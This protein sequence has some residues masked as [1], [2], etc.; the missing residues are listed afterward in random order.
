MKQGKNFIHFVSGS[1]RIVTKGNLYYW[2]WVLFLLVLIVVG[3][4]A[5]FHQLNEGLIETN[6]RD[7]VSWGFYI[8]NFTFLVGV[9]AAAVVLVIPAY[10]YHWGPIKEIV[11]LGELLAVSACVMCV[12]F[13]TVDIG[14]PER[15]WHMIP[16]LGVLNV[17]ASILDWDVVALNAYLLLNLTIVT[18]LLYCGFRKKSYRPSI[19]WP[20]VILSI[21]MAVSIHTVTAFVYNSMPARPFWNTAILAPRFLVSAFCSGPAILLVMLQILRKTTRLEIKDEAIWKIAELM[22]YAMFVNLFLQGV[23]I[24]TEFYSNTEHTLFARYMFFGLHGHEA[25]VPYAWASIACGIVAF[26]LFLNPRTRK[27]YITLNLGCFLIYIGVYLEKGM[28][29]VIP[30][31]TPD[32]LGEIYEYAPTLTEWLVTCGIF[33]VGFLLLTLMVKVAVEIS[34]GSFTVESGAGNAAPAPVNSS[35]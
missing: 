24:F 21:P 5:Y 12:L 19:V 33:S 15:F 29:L 9:A 30:G 7:Q 22:A 28:C 6:M 2:L 25:V 34:M 23:E 10:I 3:V 4:T 26:I 11:I 16:G 17:P 32:T 8:G 1:L 13:V 27:N 18:Y 14:H 35:S 31:L 20:L